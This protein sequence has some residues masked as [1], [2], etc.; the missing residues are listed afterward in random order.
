MKKKILSILMGITVCASGF[1]LPVSA[2]DTETVYTFDGY[3]CETANAKVPDNWIEVNGYSNSTSN[4]RIEIYSKKGLFGKDSDD[5]VYKIAPY[6]HKNDTQ[7][8]YYQ[9]RYAPEASINGK[10]YV[11][12]SY[13]MAV[14]LT[15][16]YRWFQI[17][18]KDSEGAA[19][20]TPKLFEIKKEDGVCVLYVGG[21]KQ[22]YAVPAEKWMRFD[23]VCD[24]TDFTADLY[25]DGKLI[26]TNFALNIDG[27]LT[28][29]NQYIYGVNVVKNGSAYGG[30]QTY[31]DNVSYMMTDTA[32]EIKAYTAPDVIDF[33]GYAGG[34]PKGYNSTSLAYE[35]FITV[36]ANDKQS[37]VAYS[38]LKGKSADDTSLRIKADSGQSDSKPKWA[39]YRW[40]TKTLIDASSTPYFHFS[41]EFAMEGAAMNRGIALEGYHSSGSKEI[42]VIDIK[43]VNGKQVV[44]VNNQETDL[45][46][47][48]GVLMKFD[49]VV[50]R[51]ALTFDLYING[52]KKFEN[53]K[54]TGLDY[55]SGINL[56]SLYANQIWEFTGGLPT[57]IWTGVLSNWNGYTQ[58]DT[59]YDNMECGKYYSYPNIEAYTSPSVTRM[60]AYDE[61]VNPIDG[62]KNFG[63]WVPLA[64]YDSEYYYYAEKVSMPADD[65]V[66][67]YKATFGK[68]NDS[69]IFTDNNIVE[70]KNGGLKAYNKEF[71][72][73]VPTDREFKL[74]FLF[75]A[76]NKTYNVY[77]DD[78]PVVVELPFETTAAEPIME[79]SGI[80]EYV[81]AY[82]Q[83]AAVK[84][85][86][87]ASGSYVDIPKGSEYKR[88]ETNV[89]GTI[90]SV[91]IFSNSLAGIPILAVYDSEGVLKKVVIGQNDQREISVDKESYSTVNFMLWKDF[92]FIKPVMN[93]VNVK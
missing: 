78:E 59:Y 75:D 43:L 61:I 27:N 36:N 13:E 12:V 30:S 89:T 85:T 83:A 31:L 65:A 82:G 15:D 60:V 79:F 91:N 7:A 16:V 90:A 71:G 22:N 93:K 74:S 11:K 49:I 80:E 17:A 73:V 2:E 48:M 57:K 29:L 40:N 4:N 38:G 10:R 24:L 58:S 72:N 1:A 51:A 62:T 84:E 26:K 88:Y 39:Q 67:A 5:T 52:E 23:A 92:E 46:L 32:P 8:R 56:V 44:Y 42:R 18:F 14:N 47:P 70:V 76:V 25:V 19:K 63:H 66:R 53:Q 86:P 21:E 68:K 35:D 37:L 69:P 33:Q 54:I 28:V 50:D 9:T 41:T 34:T 64:G 55:M 20:E 77:I 81:T 87:I 45:Q 6:W 3:V